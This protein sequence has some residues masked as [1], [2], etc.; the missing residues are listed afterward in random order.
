MK[1][2]GSTEL[3]R[4][5]VG[6]LAIAGASAANAATV[7]ITFNGSYISSTGGNHL[8]TDFGND[9]TADVGG[10]VITGLPVEGVA[11]LGP[12][13]R[14]WGTYPEY[15][16]RAWFSN[17]ELKNRATVGVV[18]DVMLVGDVS[19]RGMVAIVFND[20]NIRGGTATNGYLDLTASVT[21]SDY[22]VTVQRLIFDDA[23][24]G[25]I[26]GLNVSNAAFPEFTVVPEPSSLGLLALG[27]GGLLARRRRA[28]AA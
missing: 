25:T 10:R 23:T 13:R 6:A 21:G 18:E 8:V 26:A 15:I 27:A 9:G 22:R 5:A 14:P 12:V 4:F 19:A 7:Q 11:V 28:M 16:G 1:R 24:G 3:P 20:D 17:L 2:Q